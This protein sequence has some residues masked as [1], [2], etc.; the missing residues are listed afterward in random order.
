LGD[1][2]KEDSMQGKK[3]TAEQIVA[4]LREAEVLLA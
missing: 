1:G 4:E 3:N 2:L